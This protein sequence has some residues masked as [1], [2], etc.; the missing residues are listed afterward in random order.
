[1][2]IAATIARVLL[3]LAFTVFGL[4]GLLHFM[5]SPPIAGVAGQFARLLMVSHYM[6]AVAL[7]QLVCG[8]LFIVNRY[9]PLALTMLAPVLVNI[10]LF[11]LLMSP[12]D[13]GAGVVATI[14]WLIVFASVRHAFDGILQPTGVGKS[15]PA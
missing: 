7:I 15:V 6:L 3:G 5:P 8:I 2:K 12:R 10:L 11:H 13:I 1:M 9:V 14:C 4:N